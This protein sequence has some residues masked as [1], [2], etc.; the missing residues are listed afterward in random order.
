MG[1]TSLL[2][3]RKDVDFQPAL[4]SAT[5][6]AMLT[7]GTKFLVIFLVARQY[8]AEMRLTMLWG[9]LPYVQFLTDR[10]TFVKIVSTST[11]AMSIVA[12][13]AFGL[14][15]IR[16]GR[17]QAVIGWWCAVLSIIE[18]LIVEAVMHHFNPP[19]LDPKLMRWTLLVLAASLAVTLAWLII[20]RPWQVDEPL[21]TGAG[22][23]AL[24]GS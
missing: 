21:D 8:S 14:A 18:T 16:G 15:V 17:R 12:G 1:T 3:T 23:P 13:A 9:W 22:H 5:R 19:Y 24:V 11:L 7:G 20:D 6:A 4:R 2:E 10:A